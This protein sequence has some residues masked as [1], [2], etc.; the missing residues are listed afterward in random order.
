MRP[1]FVLP[2]V[3]AG[4]VALVGE[5]P[6]VVVLKSS[7]G[8]AQTTRAPMRGALRTKPHARVACRYVH[9][10]YSTGR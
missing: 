2:L 10:C 7:H 9:K 3:L 1:R 5:R 6:A 8:A 4:L